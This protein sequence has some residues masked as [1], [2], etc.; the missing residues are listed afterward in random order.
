MSKRTDKLCE[1]IVI[2]QSKDLTRHCIAVTRF[3]RK[4]VPVDRSWSTELKT[5][6]I[7]VVSPNKTIQTGTRVKFLWK[8][9]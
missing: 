4:F 2:D 7:N 5:E 3:G 8:S 1:G 9:K 6:E